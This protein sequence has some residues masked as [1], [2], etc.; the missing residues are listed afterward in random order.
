M[1]MNEHFDLV[2]P[3]HEELNLGRLE[4]TLLLGTVV[5]RDYNYHRVPRGE[6]NEGRRRR[7]RE[8]CGLRR[9]SGRGQTSPH[10]GQDAAWAWMG[11]VRGG[12]AVRQCGPVRIWD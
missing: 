12:D 6:G 11:A 7:P 8:P 4:R 3:R 10:G 1:E 2:G 9:P 5:G